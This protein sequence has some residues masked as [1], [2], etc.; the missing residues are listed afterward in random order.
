MGRA[1]FSFLLRFELIF[2]AL[3]SKLVLPPVPTQTEDGAFS[4]VHPMPTAAPEYYASAELLRR[5]DYDMGHDTCG[6]GA[7]NSAATYKCY[8][9][10]GTCENIG[11]YRGCCTSGLKACSSTFW[12]K[13][14]DYDPTSICGTSLKT[15]CCGSA[16]P[17]CI[18]WLFSVSMKFMILKKTCSLFRSSTPHDYT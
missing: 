18:T 3:A 17:Y 4:G 12:T 6:F 7:L 13:C 1:L 10:V 5:Q 15:R 9:S 16:L 2:V 8:S 11:N 14:D